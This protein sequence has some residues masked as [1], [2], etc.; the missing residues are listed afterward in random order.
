MNRRSFLSLSV[1]GP[2]VALVG[3]KA[4]PSVSGGCLEASTISLRLTCDFAEFDRA[5]DK[6][7][8]ACERLAHEFG[9]ELPCAL[10]SL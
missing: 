2:L 9:R 1:A 4:A 8:L 3:L 10:G 5:I 6:A 7:I